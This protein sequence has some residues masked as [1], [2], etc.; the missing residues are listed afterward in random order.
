MNGVAVGGKTKD[1][2]LTRR[3]QQDIDRMIERWE[4]EPE[5]VSLPQATV[6]RTGRRRK[7]EP[8]PVKALIPMET[9]YIESLE[10]EGEAI[11]WTD[12]AVLVR[13]V[14]KPGHR[15]VEVWVWASA[16]QRR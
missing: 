14:V 11:A 16:V 4:R 5:H 13:A 15:A 1:G 8:V 3:G 10:V 2:N 6:D 9:R 7:G 12:R